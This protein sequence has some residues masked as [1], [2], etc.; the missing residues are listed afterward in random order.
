MLKTFILKKI[1][2]CPECKNV[3]D[4]R[5]IEGEFIR[6]MGTLNGYIAGR[7]RKESR[8][9]YR[10]NNPEKCKKITNEWNTKN[11]DRVKERLRKR[12]EEERDEL[13]KVRNQPN[14]CACGGRYTNN[15]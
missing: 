14:A 1:Q 3:E 8:D 2:D 11:A 13:N 15:T 9:E 5:K 10:A 12:W 6:S 4:L 7:T